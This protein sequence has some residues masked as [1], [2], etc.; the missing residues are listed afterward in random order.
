MRIPESASSMDLGGSSSE[1]IENNDD[2]SGE[3]FRANID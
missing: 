1:S 2:R 3:R